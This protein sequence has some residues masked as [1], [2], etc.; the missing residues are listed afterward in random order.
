MP[1]MGLEDE[2]R[3]PS[4]GLKLTDIPSKMKGAVQKKVEATLW[5]LFVAKMKRSLGL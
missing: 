4:F 3:D 2:S 5:D 1:I